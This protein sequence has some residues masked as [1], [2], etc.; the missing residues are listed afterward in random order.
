[1]DSPTFSSFLFYF[2]SFPTLSFSS[3]HWIF[4]LHHIFN[5]Q[6]SFLV[7]C[8]SFIASCFCVT[9]ISY[10]VPLML[11]INY[12]FE[13][14]FSLHCLFAPVPFH[15]CVYFPYHVAGV[16]HMVTD[17]W[18]APHT[19]EWDSKHFRRNSL[20]GVDRSEM[21]Q[22]HR[23]SALGVLYSSPRSWHCL[24]W[25]MGTESVPLMGDWSSAQARNQRC[26]A[27]AS[28]L[29]KKSGRSCYA[30]CLRL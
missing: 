24:P 21:E 13:V 11:L 17:S 20:C 3:F 12:S 28:L 15:F 2:P 14:P 4:Y 8:S 18:T 22:N 16:H 25:V 9:G 10:F 7:E 6:E 5:F 29:R 23:D 26:W 27:K 1:M 19:E 30:C